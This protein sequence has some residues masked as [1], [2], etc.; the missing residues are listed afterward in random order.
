MTLSEANS[1][2]KV[3]EEAYASNCSFPGYNKGNGTGYIL[4][5]ED[6][7][8]Y[9]FFISGNVYNPNYRYRDRK[10]VYTYWLSKTEAKEST[11]EVEVSESISNVQKW[12]KY[13]EK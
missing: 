1:V 5:W 7:G 13:I 10:L 2:P 3:A 9:V 8:T 12:V 6:G 4:T 11:S